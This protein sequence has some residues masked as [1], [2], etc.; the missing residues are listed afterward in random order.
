[1]AA[2]AHCTV[3]MA[4]EVDRDTGRIAIL[5]AVAATDCGQ[6]A[7]PDG[8]RNQIE[9]GIVQSVSWTTREEAIRTEQLRGSF[10]WS[11]YPILRFADVPQAIEVHIVERPG[12]AFLGVAEAAMGPAAAALANAFADATGVRI[13][14]MPLSPRAV[15][16]ALHGI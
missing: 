7:N 12:A 3:M 9:G 1:M 5:R 2:C 6:P 4:I 8:I 16:A 14:D 13:R 15:K 10:D 11:A